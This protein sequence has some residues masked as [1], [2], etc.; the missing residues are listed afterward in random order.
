VILQE[1]YKKKDPGK[2]RI[3]KRKK[4]KKERKKERKTHLQTSRAPSEVLTL[5]SII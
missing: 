2:E 5:M 3:Y 1:T 4:N